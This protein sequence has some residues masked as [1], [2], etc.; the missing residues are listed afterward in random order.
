MIE[1]NLSPDGTEWTLS[2][3]LAR[4]SIAGADG[5]KIGSGSE[6]VRASMREQRESTGGAIARN[7]PWREQ[8]SG[9]AYMELED[10][11]YIY[12][13]H[14]ELRIRGCRSGTGKGAKL[15]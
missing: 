13:K 9:A 10:T 6:S 2:F 3:K 11:I 14:P 8:Y 4:N 5:E 12:Y 1:L 15:L 7:G